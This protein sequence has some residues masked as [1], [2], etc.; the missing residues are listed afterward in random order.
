MKKHLQSLNH[1]FNLFFYF[2]FIFLNKPFLAKGA[3]PP[4]QVLLPEKKLIEESF[5]NTKLDDPT[6]TAKLPSGDLLTQFIPSIIKILL[7]ISSLL[8]LL[9]LIVAGVLMVTA[10]GDTNQVDKAKKVIIYALIGLLVTSVAYAVTLGIVK[11]SLDST[12]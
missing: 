8:I 11:L 9:A 6:M 5:T 3:T 1:Q 4:T 12:T 2:L 7:Q 10:H